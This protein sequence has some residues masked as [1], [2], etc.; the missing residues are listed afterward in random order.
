MG[1]PAKYIRPKASLIMYL[2]GRGQ[3]E[4]L[5]KESQQASSRHPYP[6]ALGGLGSQKSPILQPPLAVWAPAW[7]TGRH[8]LL[9]QGR[10]CLLSEPAT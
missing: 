5:Q 3:R 10:S 2:G 4:A 1:K 7:P 9:Y 6:K 8:P